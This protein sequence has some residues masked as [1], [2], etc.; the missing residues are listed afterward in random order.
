MKEVLL[1]RAAL[2]R[3]TPGGREPALSRREK[4]GECGLQRGKGKRCL[5]ALCHQQPQCCL[6]SLPSTASRDEQVCYNDQGTRTRKCYYSPTSFF[7]S[8]F[9]LRASPCAKT[10]ISE[11]QMRECLKGPW[12]YHS[13]QGCSRQVFPLYTTKDCVW[14]KVLDS[15]GREIPQSLGNVWDQSMDGVSPCF[16]MGILQVNIVPTVLELT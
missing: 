13:V 14:I 9:P 16:G 5:A 15:L 12:W 1:H 4:K 6:R 11:S 2:V 8:I 3:L 10:P 7:E